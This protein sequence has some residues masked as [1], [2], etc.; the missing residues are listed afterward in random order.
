[1]FDAGLLIARYKTVVWERISDVDRAVQD[2]VDGLPDGQGGGGRHPGREV[3]ARVLAA[4]TLVVV[5]GCI[6]TGWWRTEQDRARTTAARASAPARNGHLVFVVPRV[7]EG[8]VRYVSARV[9]ADDPVEYVVP[10]LPLC[11]GARYG[12]ASWQGYVFWIQY[13]LAPRPSACGAAARWRIYLGLVPPEVPAAD[14]WSPTL[15]LVPAGRG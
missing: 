15:A 8:F 4:V 1:V 9:P 12:R 5:A 10:G 13:R 6:G 7:P 2:P 3:A 11:G 14:R